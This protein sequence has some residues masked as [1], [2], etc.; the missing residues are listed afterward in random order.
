MI[1]I[2]PNYTWKEI[3]TTV[4]ALKLH[5][6]CDLSGY[7]YGNHTEVWQTHPAYLHF[8]LLFACPTYSTQNGFMFCRPLALD[9]GQRDSQNRETLCRIPGTSWSDQSCK[10]LR[11]MKL[12]SREYFGLPD[13]LC[14]CML[15]F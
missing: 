5:R 9:D 8:V 13:A 10:E 1:I 2:P 14:L 15:A 12:L 3:Q 4:L 11:K 6:F 7:T